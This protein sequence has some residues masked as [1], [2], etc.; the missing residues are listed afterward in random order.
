MIRPSPRRAL[1]PDFIVRLLKS[2]KT[3]TQLAAIGGFTISQALDTVLRADRVSETPK[4]VMRM[5]RL[6]DAVG[7][8]RH[9]I[10]VDGEFHV[11]KRPVAAPPTAEP[12]PIE[13]ARMIAEA[14]TND[15]VTLAAL[16][17]E[18]AHR[19]VAKLE[20]AAKTEEPS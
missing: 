13:K 11:I 15:E 20:E 17:V 4:L 16:R 5:F 7:F 6:A 8:P 1:N 3:R 19:L 14:A 2:G 9:E 10:F 18:H 12:T